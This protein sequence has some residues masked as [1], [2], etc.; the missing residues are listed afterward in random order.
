[1]YELGLDLGK[2]FSV[3]V[4]L[5]DGI[6]DSGKQS[7]PSS[8]CTYVPIVLVCNATLLIFIWRHLFL[9]GYLAFHGI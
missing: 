9:Q 1:M 3:N 4:P 7:V 5:K 2:Y 8:V 6:D